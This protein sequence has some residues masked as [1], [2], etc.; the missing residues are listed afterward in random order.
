[1]LKICGMRCNQES[2]RGRLYIQYAMSILL[3][4]ALK[5]LALS[6]L[7]LFRGNETPICFIKRKCLLLI[8]E[9][10]VMAIP[11]DKV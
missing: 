2:S 3:N 7:H 5:Q 11:C 1:M 8:N 9:V 6:L 10:A 4:E